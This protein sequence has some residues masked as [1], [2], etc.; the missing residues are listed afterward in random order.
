M[1]GGTAWANRAEVERRVE[2]AIRLRPDV[3]R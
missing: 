2:E 3:V 1:T